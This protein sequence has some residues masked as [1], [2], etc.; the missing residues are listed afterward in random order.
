[1]RSSQSSYRFFALGFLCIC[2][3]W[4]YMLCTWTLVDFVGDIY[5]LSCCRL[6]LLLAHWCLLDDLWISIAPLTFYL[7]KYHTCRKVE[8]TVQRAPIILQLVFP[9]WLKYFAIFVLCLFLS[10]AVSLCLS[11]SLSPHKNRS[12]SSQSK[13]SCILWYYTYCSMYPLWKKSMLIT[14]LFPRNWTW[15]Q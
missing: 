1:M 9:P 14:S 5:L 8:R 4:F 3:T 7:E 11:V 6:P 2:R 15:I 12:K 13:V 10:V